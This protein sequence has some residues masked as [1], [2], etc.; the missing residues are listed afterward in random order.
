MSLYSKENFLIK[1][2]TGIYYNIFYKDKN[3]IINVYDKNRK[4][5]KTK[6]LI[7]L[8]IVD[9]SVDIDN[10]DKIQR[11]GEKRDVPLCKEF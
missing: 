5:L 9:F 1:T 11:L 10:N 3:I 4:I 8:D 7:N 6:E 2:S